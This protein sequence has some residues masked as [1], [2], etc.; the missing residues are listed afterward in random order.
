[1]NA[2]IR[3]KVAAVTVAL[4]ASAGFASS[5]MSTASAES[6]D[7]QRAIEV[8]SDGT[9]IEYV[10]TG[11][12]VWLTSTGSAD[13]PPAMEMQ[14]DGTSFHFFPSPSAS[15]PPTATLTSAESGAAYVG[16]A[17]DTRY[18]LTDGEVIWGHAA[19]QATLAVD[20]MGPVTEIPAD[21]GPVYVGMAGNIK[22]IV[23][24]NEVIW[25]VVSPGTTL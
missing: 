5:S 19:A 16:T 8:Q 13:Q 14:S 25:G 17:G 6:S 18:V 12:D 23:T 15:Q 2:S 20:R 21:G 3:S 22:Y 4:V 7:G 9:V 10:Q 1:M 11:N 24:S